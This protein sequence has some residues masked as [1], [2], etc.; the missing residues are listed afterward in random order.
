MSW[1]KYGLEIAKAASYR[2]EDPYLKVGACVLRGDRSIISIGYNG[3]APGVNI[4]WEDRD[5]RRGFVIHAEVNALRYCTPDQTKNGYLYTT[6]HPCAECIKVI[7]SYGITYVMYSDLI[8]G[9]VYD[10]SS[11]AELAK[12][13]NISLK[14]EVKQ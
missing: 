5:A 10:L 1:D 13:F 9:A 2:S 3:T 7:S 12:A 14:Q 8:D 11:I 4:P 6:H